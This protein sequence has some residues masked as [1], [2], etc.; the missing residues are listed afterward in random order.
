MYTTDDTN[1]TVTY[2][3]NSGY[4]AKDLMIP[5]KVTDG[6]VE[7]NV[8]EIGAAAFE[9]CSGL[10]GNLTIGNT[11]RIIEDKAFEGCTNLVGNLIIPNSVTLIGTNAFYNLGCFDIYLEST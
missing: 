3:G 2:I 9:N 1:K 11:I 10:I 4:V 5:N 8:T 6:D 7:Y